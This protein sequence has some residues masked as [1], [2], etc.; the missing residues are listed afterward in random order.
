MQTIRIEIWG[1]VQGV[2]Y[3]YYCCQHARSLMVTG[4]V[5]N[6]DNGNVEVIASGTNEQLDELVQWCKKGPL[7]AKVTQIDITAMPLQDF[8]EFSIQR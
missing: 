6:L 4:L 3:R 8:P 1:K 5:R 7:L 2:S